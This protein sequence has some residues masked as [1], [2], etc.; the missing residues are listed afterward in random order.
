M[1]EVEPV[2][3]ENDYIVIVYPPTPTPHPSVQTSSSTVTV[4][5]PPVPKRVS[6][7]SAIDAAEKAGVAPGGYAEV[8]LVRDVIRFDRAPIAPLV[9][10]GGRWG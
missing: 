9:K 2:A 1:S 5:T 10:Q 8:I 4:A 6:A 7:P 3:A